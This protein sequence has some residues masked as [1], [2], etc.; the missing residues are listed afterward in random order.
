MIVST[1]LKKDKLRTEDFVFPPNLISKCYTLKDNHPASIICNTSANSFILLEEDLAE[2]WQKILTS[3]DFNS[4]E[5]L[6]IKHGLNLL[7]AKSARHGFMDQLIS[8]LN[9]Q[10]NIATADILDFI[11]K[12]HI[13]YELTVE[14]THRCNERC[15]HCYCPSNTRKKEIDT[16]TFKR[17][18]DEFEKMGGFRLGL[19]GG[20]I[21]IR[22]D[23]EKI[24][25]MLIDRNMVVDIN[26]NLTLLDSKKLDLIANIKTLSVGVTIHSANPSIHDSITRVKG[27][28]HKTVSSIKKLRKKGINV[29]IK[30]L[31]FD[32]NISS[33]TR[34]KQLAI[35]LDSN[36]NFSFKILPNLTSSN[37][38]LDIKPLNRKEISKV[39]KDLKYLIPKPSTRNNDRQFFCW[40]GQNGLSIS[41]CGDIKAC[42][43]ILESLGTYP[44]QS[45]FEVWNGNKLKKI[46]S[47]LMI[48]N[49]KKCLKCRY[50][51]ICSL[52]V[53]SLEKKYEP[54]AYTCLL[55]RLRCQ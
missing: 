52:C 51:S 8:S 40:A 2:L 17:L 47:S 29:F 13:L 3:T 53:G 46:V 48:K 44:E 45:L 4:V 50:V 30:T 55:T 41:P 12:N 28:F 9:T 11:H 21:L 16:V 35:D 42:I 25:K 33:Y 43:Q 39:F 14:L 15:Q 37:K 22:E 49:F 27:S 24:L 18:I 23:I 31:L 26:S 19:T 34:L 5:E 36:I 10:N 7:E 32:K 54:D 20:E 1:V 6:I 38:K